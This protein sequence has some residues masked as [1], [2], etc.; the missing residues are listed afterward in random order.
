MTKL[1]TALAAENFE[2]I[3]EASDAILLGRGDLGTDIGFE[4]VPSVQRKVVRACRR[5][6][7][8]VIVATQMLESMINSP[9][10]TRAEVSDVATAVC[11]EA[12]AVMLSAETASGKYPFE[13]VKT[14]DRVIKSTESDSLRIRDLEC[15]TLTPRKTTT[16]ALCTA[17]K[18]AAEYSDANAIALFTD[19]FATV[20]RCSATRPR[21]PII[22]VTDSVS[23]AGKAGLCCG[24]YPAVEK[25]NVEQIVKTARS[26]V[27]ERRLATMGDN[28]II[29]NDITAKSVEIC[30]VDTRNAIV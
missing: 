26:V 11:Q 8:P 28:I 2:A 20:L 12:D 30:K 18:E 10:P 16:D 4:N 3:I 13:A 27:A 29:V 15:D 9:T 22:L 7:R 1:E 14:M 25:I 17:A 19:S 5:M 24:V 6:G 23:L 21:I